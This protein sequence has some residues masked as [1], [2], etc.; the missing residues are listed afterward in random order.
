MACQKDFD[1]P[2]TVSGAALSSQVRY[3]GKNRM[4][5]DGFAGKNREM[6]SSATGF[7]PDYC[8]ESKGADHDYRKHCTRFCGCWYGRARTCGRWR[9]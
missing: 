7:C 6:R 5:F 4:V 8:Y 2:S 1:E 3:P 9:G